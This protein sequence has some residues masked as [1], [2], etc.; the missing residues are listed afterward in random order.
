MDSPG[1][2]I[3]P[4]IR[5]CLFFCEEMPTN[6]SIEV[7]DDKSNLRF[8]SPGEKLAVIDC[9][10]QPPTIT[11]VLAKHYKANGIFANSVS[12]PNVNR[13]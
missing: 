4:L 5:H 12:M 2:W 11:F 7:E 6:S 9:V 1:D 10:N 8:T 3:S 13:F